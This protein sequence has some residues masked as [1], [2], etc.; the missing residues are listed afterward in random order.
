[1]GPDRGARRARGASGVERG[2]PRHLR[3]RAPGTAVRGRGRGAGWQ[4]SVGGCVIRVWQPGGH[5]M[6]E[7]GARVEDWYWRPTRRRLGTLVRLTRPYRT[8]TLLSV[9]SLLLATATA[10]APP[11]L[12]KYA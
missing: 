3:A 12:S 7:R 5:L 8:R 6:R 9:V 10:L 4:G 1:P 11:L 2:L